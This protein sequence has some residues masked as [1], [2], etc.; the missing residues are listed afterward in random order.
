[1]KVLGLFRELCSGLGFVSGL[2]P[3]RGRSERA[4]FIRHRG[5]FLECIAERRHQI[6]GEHRTE[7]LDRLRLRDS[8]C[9]EVSN[10][11][12]VSTF[13]SRAAASGGARGGAAAG[14]SNCARCDEIGVL[15]GGS[16]RGGR[17]VQ[18]VQLRVC[19]ALCFWI[20]N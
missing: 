7:H 14:A 8:V 11:K 2:A 3:T 13:S 6:G 20:W 9:L 12:S 5:A 18:L 4:S 1:M 19:R 10:H 16:V 15:W 17:H